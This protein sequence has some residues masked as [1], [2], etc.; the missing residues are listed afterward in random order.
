VTIEIVEAVEAV[1]GIKTIEGSYLVMMGG[2]MDR[3]RDKFRFRYN[4]GWVLCGWMS[5]CIYVW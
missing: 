2:R 5:V 3:C 1:D 4:V